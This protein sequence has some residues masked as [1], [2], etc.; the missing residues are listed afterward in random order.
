MEH[1][2]IAEWVGWSK[3]VQNIT[4]GF[5]VRSKIILQEK[6]GKKLS[7]ASLCNS[8]M[9]TEYADLPSK[10]HRTEQKLHRSR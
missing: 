4:N 7:I 5:H 9:Q 2:Q 10:A 8:V 6:W 3:L 1:E